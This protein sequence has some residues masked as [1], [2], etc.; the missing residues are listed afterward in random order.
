MSHLDNRVNGKEF[1]RERVQGREPFVR[2]PH[3]FEWCEKFTLTEEHCQQLTEALQRGDAGPAQQ[4]LKDGYE[5]GL[6]YVNGRVI[7][8]YALCIRKTTGQCP[9]FKRL[10]AG[11]PA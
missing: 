9:G 3:H 5:L 6:D 1:E 2:P 11:G 4:A 8:F 10:E 7:R